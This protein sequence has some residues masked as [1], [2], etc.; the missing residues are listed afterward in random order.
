[1]TFGECLQANLYRDKYARFKNHILEVMAKS[2]ALRFHE[3]RS[4]FI[5]NETVSR[6][7]TWLRAQRSRS[8]ANRIGASTT[9]SA[10]TSR[11]C[12]DNTSRVAH[13]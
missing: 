5:H 4:G 9:P 1:M 8:F 6:I 7:K 12:R 13:G 3:Q 11:R 10:A 2:L